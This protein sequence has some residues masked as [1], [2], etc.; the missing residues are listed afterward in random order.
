MPAATVIP[1]LHYPDVARAINW[2]CD[3]FDFGVRLR[4]GSHRAQLLAGDGAIV[5]AEGGQSAGGGLAPAH[6]TMVRVEDIDR[7]FERARQH[8][9]R[10]LQAPTDFPY[11]ERQ[12]TVADIAGHVWTFSQTMM[13]VDP[14]D[15]GGVSS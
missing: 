1:V 2:L 12:Y 6:S 3:A 5:V 11:G 10:V 4:V 13:D 9:A 8:G 15:W 14:E 7:H